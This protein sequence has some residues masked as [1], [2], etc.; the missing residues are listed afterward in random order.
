MKSVPLQTCVQFNLLLNVELCWHLVES[1]GTASC[2]KSSHI[3]LFRRE[4]QFS[5]L[6]RVHLFVSVTSLSTD[7]SVCLFSELLLWRGLQDV[8]GL[9][10]PTLPSTSGCNM[11]VQMSRV[12]TPVTSSLFFLSP[13]AIVFTFLCCPPCLLKA[14]LPL[15][16]FFFL[17]SN[18]F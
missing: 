2:R 10:Y 17:E 6:S 11:P 16:P 4:K 13:H 1:E 14:Y 8:T 18:H 3:R 9:D 12:L 5:F 7:D 15:L